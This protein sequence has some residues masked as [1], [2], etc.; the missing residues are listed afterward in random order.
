LKRPNKEMRI[1]RFFS[2]L[3]LE[4]FV[5]PAYPFAKKIEEYKTENELLK[6]EFVAYLTRDSAQKVIEFYKEELKEEFNIFSEEKS[7]VIF[8]GKSGR[9]ARISVSCYDNPEHKSTIVRI[10]YDLWLQKN[11]FGQFSKEEVQG[12]DVFWLRRYP[13]S[14]RTMYNDTSGGGFILTYEV[15]EKCLKCVVDYYRTELLS[16]GWDL[17]NEISRQPESSLKRLLEMVPSLRQDLGEAAEPLLKQ[18]EALSVTYLLFFEK[19]KSRCI[20]IINQLQGWVRATV[21]YIP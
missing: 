8:L 15:E 6:A 16:W 1:K 10:I 14:I 3:L 17:I 2:I 4:T 5:I 20:L 9:P 21:Q 13:R 7:Q 19:E 18:E 11:P 12:K